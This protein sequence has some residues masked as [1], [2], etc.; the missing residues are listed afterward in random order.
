MIMKNRCFELFKNR[1]NATKVVG[2]LIHTDYVQDYV[3]DAV[4]DVP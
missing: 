1:D 3:H 4:E 2:I